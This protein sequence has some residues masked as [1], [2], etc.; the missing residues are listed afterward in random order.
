MCLFSFTKKA[1]VDVKSNFCVW[2]G[3]SDWYEGKNSM[4]LVLRIGS[5]LPQ[6]QNRAEGLHARWAMCLCCRCFLSSSLPV[7]IYLTS[8]SVWEADLSPPLLFKASPSRSLRRWRTAHLGWSCPRPL[9]T[10][11][12]PSL[13]R[14]RAS[15]SSSWYPTLGGTLCRKGRARAGRG[16]SWRSPQFLHLSWTAPSSEWSTPSW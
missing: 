3:S 13:L 11:P 6:C 9:S 15:R 1:R 4:L 2:T 10:R 5:D 12:R 16:S 7:L 8:L 14:G